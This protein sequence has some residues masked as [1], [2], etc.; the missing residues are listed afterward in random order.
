M[1][2]YIIALLVVM[3]GSAPAS[4]F[5]QEVESLETSAERE[6]EFE[7]H[8][9]EA[10]EHYEARRYEQAIELFER[11]YAVMQEPELVY[12]IARSHERLLHREEA[13]LGYE[14]F[15]ELPGTTGELRARALTNLSNV[16]QEIA[17]LEAAQR[18][19]AQ[20][21]EAARQEQGQQAGQQQG[22]HSEEQTEPQRHESPGVG[23][24]GIAGYALLGVGIATSIVGGVFWGLAWASNSDFEAAGND[25]SRLQLSDEFRTRSLVGDVLFFSGLAVLCTGIALVVADAVRRRGRSAVGSTSMN[26][27]GITPALVVGIGGLGVNGRF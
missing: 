15:L 13:V 20:Q 18:A 12:N 22:P 4:T 2:T 23:S 17:A 26:K 21:A 16:R 25:E 27:R 1:K 3:V 24:L 10:M 9:Q 14:R 7:G 5:G 11:A 19:E 8:V 6:A